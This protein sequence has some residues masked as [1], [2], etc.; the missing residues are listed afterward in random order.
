[1]AALETYHL[2]YIN[3]SQLQHEV[4][5]LDHLTIGPVVMK[6][7][8]DLEPCILYWKVKILLKINDIRETTVTH[9]SNWFNLRLICFE[10]L[11]WTLERYLKLKINKC[12]TLSFATM[13]ELMHTSCSAGNQQDEDSKKKYKSWSF[14]SQKQSLVHRWLSEK[15]SKCFRSRII[16]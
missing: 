8:S 12:I 4:L 1:M 6:A 11:D 16:V 3:C 15:S 14:Y 9:D 13:I 10:L 2:P 7:L 5:M